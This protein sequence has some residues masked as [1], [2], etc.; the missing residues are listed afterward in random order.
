MARKWSAVCSLKESSGSDVQVRESGL[1]GKK[2]ANYWDSDHMF[3]SPM[4][5][6][7]M[8]EHLIIGACK[9]RHFPGLVSALPLINSQ[10]A[11][12]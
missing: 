11:A 6:L 2:S 12:W 10:A 5:K 1:E 4:L 9:G 3:S 8:L 7:G